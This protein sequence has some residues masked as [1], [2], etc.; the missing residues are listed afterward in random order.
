[1]TELESNDVGASLVRRISA[2][3]CLLSSQQLFFKVVISLF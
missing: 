3:G 2:F 1:M